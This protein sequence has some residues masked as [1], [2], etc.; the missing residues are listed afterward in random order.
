MVKNIR[1]YFL[2]MNCFFIFLLG[3]CGDNEDK[4]VGYWKSVKEQT[5]IGYDKTQVY[6]ISKDS[7]VIDGIHENTDLIWETKNDN[8]IA[9]KKDWPF[10]D[11]FTFEIIDD[12]HIKIW[13]RNPMTSSD[14][15]GDEFIR[16]TK[17]DAEAIIKSPGTE[18]ERIGWTAF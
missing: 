10:E 7:I 8:I 16:T 4:V 6:A 3:G 2:V 5:Y 1:I 18:H 14:P 15:D 17:E 11:E 9:N 12:N 13:R